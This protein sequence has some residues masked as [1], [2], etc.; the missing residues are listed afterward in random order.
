[1]GM[2]YSIIFL[3]DEEREEFSAFPVKVPLPVYLNAALSE[4]TGTLI[5]TLSPYQELTAASYEKVVDSMAEGVKAQG[6]GVRAGGKSAEDQVLQ[7]EPVA[8]HRLKLQRKG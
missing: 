3:V 7:D 2:K 8:V 6:S 5:M 1:M 4:C